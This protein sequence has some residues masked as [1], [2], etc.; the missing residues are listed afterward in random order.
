MR[1]KF[2]RDG[3][4]RG[5][6]RTAREWCGWR[7]KPPAM[8]GEN[9]NKTMMQQNTQKKKKRKKTKKMNWKKNTKKK[10]EKMKKKRRN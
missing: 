4:S 3:P 8:I 2:R 5:R 10:K 9:G 6:G 7:E 1:A